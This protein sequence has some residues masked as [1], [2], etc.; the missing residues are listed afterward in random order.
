M[1]RLKENLDYTFSWKDLIVID[2]LMRKYINDREK[3]YT[4]LF[5]SS[6]EFTRDD[7]NEYVEWF[8]GNASDMDVDV[9]EKDRI[10]HKNLYNIRHFFT[11]SFFLG[12]KIGFFLNFYI[13]L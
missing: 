4:E 1:A 3:M 2:K 11:I 9:A 7:V 5:D 10:H 13:F 8:M 12:K 6:E